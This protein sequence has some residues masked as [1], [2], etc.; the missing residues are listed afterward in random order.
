M[1]LLGV[2]EAGGRQGGDSLTITVMAVKTERLW[3]NIGR[4]WNNV[5]PKHKSLKG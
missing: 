1:S 4:D 3:G 2:G 5:T